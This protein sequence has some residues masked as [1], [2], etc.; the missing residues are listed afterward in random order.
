MAFTTIQGA[1]MKVLPP[2]SGYIN[3]SKGVLLRNQYLHL[4]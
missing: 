2:P 3:Q 4:D 1:E